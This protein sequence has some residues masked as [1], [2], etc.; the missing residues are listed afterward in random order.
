MVKN[1]ISKLEKELDRLKDLEKEKQLRRE[2]FRRNHPLIM[3]SAAII[4]SVPK[5][6]IGGVGRVI[7]NVSRNSN[8]TPHPIPKTMDRSVS[9]EKKIEPKIQN[10]VMDEFNFIP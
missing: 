8:P 4:E 1:N 9:K 10:E 6:V 2:I 3:K 5:K 7:N